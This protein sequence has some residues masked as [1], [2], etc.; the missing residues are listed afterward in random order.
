MNNNKS[1]FWVG[2]EI[3]K[4]FPTNLPNENELVEYMIEVMYGEYGLQAF[5]NRIAAYNS[6]IHEINQTIEAVI[7][8]GIL[9]SQWSKI[10]G[11]NLNAGIA[12]FLQAP[13]NGIHCYLAMILSEGVSI[14]TT[15]MDLCIEYAYES[16][17]EGTDKL[18]LS[19][20]ENGVA[21]YSGGRKTSG[22][23]YHIHGSAENSNCLGG[24]I[25]IGKDYF[26]KTF[27]EC[28]KEWMISDINLYVVGYN[29]RDIY[30]VTMFMSYQR[31]QLESVGW[32]VSIVSTKGKKEQPTSIKVMYQYFQECQLIHTRAIDF[33]K[34]FCLEK[35]QCSLNELYESVKQ[36]I[37]RQQ[38]FL[39]NWKQEIKKALCDV[40][41]YKDIILL[42]MNQ[43]LGVPV[44]EMD[45]T[46]YERLERMSSS[47][48]N[49]YTSL[50]FRY[51][52]DLIP[53]YGYNMHKNK[54]LEGN[55][56]F[57]MEELIRLSQDGYNQRN[58]KI[59]NFVKIVEKLQEDYINALRRRTVTIKWE[60]EAGKLLQEIEELLPKE[61]GGRLLELPK[62]NYRE[63]AQLYRLRAA[64]KSIYY[65]EVGSIL[66]VK[67]DLN[68][69]GTYCSQS[70]NWHGVLKTV[71]YASFCYYCF[72][73]KYGKKSYY[74]KAQRYKTLIKRQKAK[75]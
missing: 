47:Y 16:F 19:E 54:L 59:C 5:Q 48:K 32:K 53:I 58:S 52:H 41:D 38:A 17:M 30:D 3:N 69:A 44:C 66:D 60:I 15:N 75:E 62:N 27:R 2:S 6:F 40:G 22:K 10:K 55:P 42:Y 23:V 57:L 43:S 20:C 31:R 1:L 73:Y 64:I 33:C 46:I 68:R 71:E 21:I 70:A 56:T 4:E 24:T 28:V 50:M 45:P 51:T 18:I 34:E 65:K 9:I 26:S 37:S 11:I 25:E 29:Y 39:L 63:F 74:D 8:P 12:S 36:M 67:R 7:Y 35:R 13:F 61:R 49:M 14:I 72:Y